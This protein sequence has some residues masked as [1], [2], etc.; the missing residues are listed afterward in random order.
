MKKIITVIMTILLVFSLAACSGGSGGSGGK[1]EPKDPYEN[2]N[3]YEFDDIAVYIPKEIT[4]SKSSIENYQYCLDSNHLAV[5]GNNLAGSTVREL[6]YDLNDLEPLLKFAMPGYEFT[7]SEFGYY[8]LYDNADAGFSYAYVAVA[9]N[10]TLY[11]MNI[12]CKL[13]EKDTYGAVVKDI[14]EKIQE[15]K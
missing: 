3:K 10:D 1:P 15:K 6:G 7:K 13:E 5:F 11:E 12:A 2:Y 14:A 9:A 8:T 4:V